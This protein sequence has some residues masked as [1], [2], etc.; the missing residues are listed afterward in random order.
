MSNVSL[1]KIIVIAGTNA[2]GKSSLAIELAKRYNGE[3]IS[4]DSRQIYKGFD[5]CSGKVTK[6]EMAVVPHHLIDVCSVEE[7]YSVSDYQKAVYALVPQILSRGHVP[8][9]VGGTG[10]YISSVVHGY[11]FE[12]ELQDSDFR[13]QLEEKSVEELRAMLP[14]EAVDYFNGN[15]SD[16]HNKRRLI[17]VLERIKSGETLRQ[18]NQ[19]IFNSLQ[20]GVTWEKEILHRRIEERLKDRLDKGMVE[21]VREYLEAGRQ[22]EHLYRLGLEYRYIS[23]YVEG[24]YASFEEFS[25]ELS[26]AIKKFSKRQ[27]TWFKRDK[28][29][30]WLDME[31]DGFAQACVLINSF[32]A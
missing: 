13:K 11:R 8:F 21:E 1:P 32:L 16:L 27:M 12:K 25:R 24:K 2:S 29:I 31:N 23:W 6:A 26:Q 18:C 28:T 5:L 14:D 9:L 22:P 30:H 15:Q 20:L 7:P 10:L 3:I 4:A 17:R 19:P